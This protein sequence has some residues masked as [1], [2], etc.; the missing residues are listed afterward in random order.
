MS[1][2]IPQTGFLRLAQVLAIIPLSKSTWFEGCR[3]GR[4]PKPVK[5]GPRA[6]AWKAEDIAALVERLGLGE[7]QNHQAKPKDGKRR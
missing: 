2:T 3:A 1:V 6:S 7:M 5:I 4:Y